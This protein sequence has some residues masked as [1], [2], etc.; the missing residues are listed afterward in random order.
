MRERYVDGLGS[1]QRGLGCGADIVRGRSGSES[2]SG[3]GERGLSSKS[4]EFC[5]RGM[6]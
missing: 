5:D 4:M 6:L 2:W 1:S 3:I